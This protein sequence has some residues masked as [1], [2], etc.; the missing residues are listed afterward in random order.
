M[1][2]F[3]CKQFIMFLTSH[4]IRRGEMK[5]RACWDIDMLRALFLFKQADF[6]H[7]ISAMHLTDKFNLRRRKG[8]TQHF[9]TILLTRMCGTS[10]LIC[11]Y[12]LNLWTSEVPLNK[13]WD[14]FHFF[15]NLDFK[16]TLQFGCRNL[17]RQYEAQDQLI[18]GEEEIWLAAACT[19][20]GVAGDG[21]AECWAG[22]P[23]G[24][25]GWSVGCVESDKG[26]GARLRA[27]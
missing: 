14:I 23:I 25:S 3:Q 18:D 6:R 5:L 15:L 10:Q 17:R 27:Y 13:I 1:L 4:I 22:R 20:V 12:T 24:A 19:G 7:L 11:W 16:Q 26:S 8:R 2:A 21:D 9:P